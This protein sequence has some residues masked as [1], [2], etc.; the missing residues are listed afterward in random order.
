M[1]RW[2]PVIGWFIVQR[3]GEWSRHEYET[4]IMNEFFESGQC[5]MQVENMLEHIA[6]EDGVELAEMSVGSRDVDDRMSVFGVQIAHDK[7]CAVRHEIDGGLEGDSIAKFAAPNLENPD[8]PSPIEETCLMFPQ[9]TAVTCKEVPQGPADGF[10][11]HM[12]T[13]R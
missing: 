12:A 4:V 8:W 3:V 1:F 13:N 5:S 11:I 7:L 2:T 6:A 10:R 9:L